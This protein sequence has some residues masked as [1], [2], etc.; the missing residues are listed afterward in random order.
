MKEKVKDFKDDESCVVYT[1][2]S[3]TCEKQF[4]IYK[5]RK[6]KERRDLR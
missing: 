2:D 5:R 4:K 1:P 3:K 6:R